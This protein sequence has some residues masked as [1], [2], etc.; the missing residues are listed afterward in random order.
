[1]FVANPEKIIWL[2]MQLSVTLIAHHRS[3][4][5]PIDLLRVRV[6]NE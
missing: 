6:M 5:K 2:A 1:M 4:V 3:Y